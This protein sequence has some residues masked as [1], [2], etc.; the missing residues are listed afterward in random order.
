[1]RA[2]ASVE[3]IEVTGLAAHTGGPLNVLVVGSDSRDEL[4][5]EQRRELTLGSFDGDRTD[6]IF[7]L[8]VQG[9]AAA[10]LAFPR[11]LW[12]TRC[13]G[14]EQ[15]INTAVQVDGMSC[16]ARTVTAASGIPIHHAMVVGFGGFVEIVDAVGGVELCLDQP[17]A[18]RDAGIDLPAGCQELG[19]VDALGYVRVRKIDNDLKRI[20]RQQQ[21]LRA[22]AGEM[23]DS[24][25]LR[26]PARLWDL[27]GSVGS[28]L[29]ADDGL[30]TVGLGRLA[31]A[32]R[33]V[34]SGRVATF[35]VPASPANI[36]GADVL[37]ADRVSAD[38]LYASFRD[39]SVFATIDP[40]SEQPDVAPQDVRVR[41]RNGARVEGAAA[42]ARDAL[43]ARGYVVLDIA[44]ADEQPT[45]TV[46][47]PPDQRPEA[48]L[49]AREVATS[50]GVTP[51]LVEDT[52][53]D[54]VVLTLGTD[55]RG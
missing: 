4:T 41:V 23:T 5:E 54:A 20:E 50:I 44:N 33:G 53:A 14:R 27:S 45:T 28:A 26:S 32:M 13:D 35:T 24:A 1:V 2:S 16:L 48:E 37:L 7:V 40:A 30:G 22:L 18:D 10:M 9:G 25:T 47:F 8:S 31:W 39:G 34:A 43:T 12:V 3:R 49:L 38:P 55:L 19:G 17:I 36:G 29:S 11:D 42:S 46:A 6:T 52:S 51:E 15:R 21:F